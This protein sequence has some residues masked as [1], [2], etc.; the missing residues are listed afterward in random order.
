MPAY[1]YLIVGSGL[2][3]AT[4]AFEASKRGMKCLVLEKRNHVGGNIYTCNERG[5]NIH[6][7]GAHI[8]NTNNRAIWDYIGQFASLNNYVHTVYAIYKGN[9]YPLPFNLMTIQAVYGQKLNKVISPSEGRLLVQEYAQRDA[10]EP[11]NLEEYAISL[12]GRDIYNML[13]KGYTK[14]QWGREVTELP[15]S[16][17]TRIPFRFTYDNNYYYSTYQGIPIGGYTQIIEKMLVNCDVQL[18]TDFS[19]EEDK[20][21]ACAR[22]IVYTGTIDAFYHY[23][24]GRLEYRSLRFESEEFDDID[25]YQGNAVINY[26]DESIPYTRIIEHKHFEFGRQPFTVITREYPVNYLPEEKSDPYYP[27]N[28]QK[29]TA[30]YQR[31]RQLADE[32]TNVIIGGRLGR[33]QYTS[34]EDTLISAL[35]C[36][37]QELNKGE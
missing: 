7:Y 26:T 31:Y 12:V 15:P 28:D 8:F 25:D 33:Y 35:D 5:I 34:M 2:W 24:Y 20:W 29:N 4:F 14:K 32:E 9:I 6:I 3:G 11:R 13:I 27:I 19:L 23:R 17:M 16:I 10:L 36:V 37:K 21:R 18:E 1:D 22:H 30:L